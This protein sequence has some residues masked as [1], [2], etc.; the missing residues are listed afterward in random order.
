MWREMEKRTALLR[1]CTS[2][3]EN[4]Y[5]IPSLDILE[6]YAKALDVELYRLF[7]L[8]DG[9]PQ[10]PQVGAR[11]GLSQGE[12]ALLKAFGGLPIT[13]KRLL[14]DMTRRITATERR[15]RAAKTKQ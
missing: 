7:F 6:E 4:G 14:L 10:A 8:E 9:K 12:R 3:V 2:K 1:C 5:M 13:H 11:P 15:R